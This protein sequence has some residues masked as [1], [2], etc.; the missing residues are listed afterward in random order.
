MERSSSLFDAN[1][2]MFHNSIYTCIGLLLFLSA[3]GIIR[4]YDYIRQWKKKAEMGKTKG[5]GHVHIYS[6]GR[7]P[8][9]V[10]NGS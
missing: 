2:P 4:D 1:S 9:K 10:L 7:W 8:S 3:C 6:P 5:L